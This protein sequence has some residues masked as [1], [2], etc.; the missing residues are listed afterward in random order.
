MH[1]QRFTAGQGFWDHGG[2]VHIVR[3]EGTTTA[4]FIAT[5]LNVPPGTAHALMSRARATA[6][7]DRS[8]AFTE[9][10]SGPGSHGWLGEQLL[11]RPHLPQ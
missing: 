11:L 6:H 7:S 9:D 1:P 8:Q 2:D 5:F 3:D 10:R 4:T